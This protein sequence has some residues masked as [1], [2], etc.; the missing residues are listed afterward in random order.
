MRCRLSAPFRHIRN[1][2]ITFR[3]FLFYWRLLFALVEVLRVLFLIMFP[4]KPLLCLT[5]E[6]AVM[7]VF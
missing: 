2:G 4:Y 7:F 3:I 1:T 6:H 5:Q